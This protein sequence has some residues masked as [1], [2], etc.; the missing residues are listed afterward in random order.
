MDHVLRF[1]YAVK[2]YLVPAA[3]VVGLIIFVQYVR[4]Y[5]QIT[6]PDRY[7]EI[8]TL[9]G[10]DSVT[11]RPVDRASAVARGDLVGWWRADEKPKAGFGYVAGLPGDTVR[12]EPNGALS[13]NGQPFDMGQPLRTAGRRGAVVIP[14]GHLYVW[15]DTHMEDS[16][17]KGP[18][19]ENLLI[20]KER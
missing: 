2:S 14:A 16:T 10:D 4:S 3:L 19:A 20:G 9:S 8:A 13:V 17:V 18:I 7:N 11:L 1:I 15:S 6:L 5:T 12:I